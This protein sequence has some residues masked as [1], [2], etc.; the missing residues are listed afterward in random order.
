S[1]LLRLISEIVDIHS[2]KEVLEV[3]AKTFEYLYDENFSF[4]K[5]VSINKSTLIDD[6]CLKYK[7]AVERYAQNPTGEEEKLMVNLQ[8]K[9]ISVFYACHDLTSLNLWDDIFER[10]IRAANNVGEILPILAVKY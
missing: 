7:E 6:I 1:A 10:W 3:A 4:S 2:D 9:K 5:N 8:L